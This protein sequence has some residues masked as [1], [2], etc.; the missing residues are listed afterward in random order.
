M[1]LGRLTIS[2]G[3]QKLSS[4]SPRDSIPGHCHGYKTLPIFNFSALGTKC[5]PLRL[6]EVTYVLLCLGEGPFW[7]PP[8]FP[9]IPPKLREASGKPPLG[10]GSG[11]RLVTSK[12]I[13]V[14]LLLQFADTQVFLALNAIQ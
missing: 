5:F 8:P 12:F 7:L 3:L 6:M 11:C 1:V 10:F 4:C 13:N 2:L 9:E 14:S